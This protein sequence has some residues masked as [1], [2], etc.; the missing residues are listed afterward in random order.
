MVRLL[1]FVA[2]LTA[3]LQAQAMEVRSLWQPGD[4]AGSEA[5]MRARL[6]TATGDDALI[7]RSQLQHP[8]ETQTEVA[9]A[10]ARFAYQRA[11]TT[12]EAAGLDVLKVDALHMFAFTEPDPAEQL[13]WNQAALA[14]SLASRDPEAQRWEASLT[15]NLG[16][17]L[18]DLGRYDEALTAFLRALHLRERSTS[19][20]ERLRDAAWH[21]ART[22]RAQGDLQAA[23]KLQRHIANEA[24][25]ADAQRPYF[26]EELALLY[27]A[28]GD[29]ARAQHFAEHAASLRP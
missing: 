18:F 27:A 22:L 15:S 3:T 11:L 28:L 9:R 16:E 29:E 10:R 6:A 20:P 1:V 17:T 7:V 13:R 14:E 4:L 2:A 19:R 25:D 26:H 23:L 8:P 5:V 12:A 21:V 24:Y